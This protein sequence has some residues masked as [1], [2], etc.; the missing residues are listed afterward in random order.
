M[1][2]TRSM[3]DYLDKYRIPY[4]R[5]V[6]N[7]PYYDIIIDDKAIGIPLKHFNVDWDEIKK[8]LT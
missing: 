7:K 2:A 8:L 4:N 5:V 3:V 1:D 6:S